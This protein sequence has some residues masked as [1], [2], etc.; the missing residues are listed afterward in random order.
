MF[1][2]RGRRKA[3]VLSARE[4]KSEQRGVAL[5]RAHQRDGDT[6]NAVQVG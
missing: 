2:Q 3:T 1:E 6:Q 4:D 5:S